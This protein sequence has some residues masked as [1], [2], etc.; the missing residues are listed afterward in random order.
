MD[1]ESFL[2][3]IADQPDADASRLVYAD[4]LEDHGDPT[5]AEFIRVQMQLAA[6]DE[7]DGQRPALAERERD[8]LIEHG[9]R[10]ARVLVDHAAL[11]WNFRRGTLHWAQYTLVDF[12]RHGETA[13]ARTPVRRIALTETRGGLADLAASPLLGR[14][15]GLDLARP[16]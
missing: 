14:L 11:N 15:H 13:L 2:S 1:R 10:W 3:A 5:Q 8:L 9:M 7:H 4:W 16:E 12:L 6:L